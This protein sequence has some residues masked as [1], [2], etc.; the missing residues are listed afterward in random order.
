M[1]TNVIENEPSL[2]NE[3]PSSNDEFVTFRI[4]AMIP[5]RKFNSVRGNPFIG[6]E[7]AES[8]LLG[9]PAISNYLGYETALPQL[10][11]RPAQRLVHLLIQGGYVFYKM[12][13][14]LGLSRSN[15]TACSFKSL[16]DIFIAKL[17]NQPIPETPNNL[18]QT[19][20]NIF[21]FLRIDHSTFVNLWLPKLEA[22]GFIF[23]LNGKLCAFEAQLKA[24]LVKYYYGKNHNWRMDNA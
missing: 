9:W 24:A 10:I 17:R 5:L 23:T 19:Q 11:R 12:L 21:R 1:T 3:V 8:M 2:S 16:L 15:R 20:T 6:L 4:K 18:I 22:D 13:R 7:S 14:P